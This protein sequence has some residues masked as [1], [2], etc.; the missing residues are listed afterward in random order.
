MTKQELMSDEELVAY[1]DKHVQNS[2]GFTSGQ[3][4]AERLENFRFYMGLPFGNEIEGR[5][6]VVMTDVF[7]TIESMLPSFMRVFTST[8][9][10][11]IFEPN[12]QEDEASAEQATE[13][14][15]YLIMEKNPGFMNTY[16]A[17]KDALLSKNCVA[18]V[19]YDENSEEITEDYDELSE[20]EAMAILND[21]DVEELSH[22]VQLRDIGNDQTLPIYSMKIKKTIPRAGLKWEIIPPEEFLISRRSPTIDKAEFVAHRYTKPR[23]E[24]IKEGYDPDMVAKLPANDDWF[25][26]QEKV[27]RF[28]IEDSSGLPREEMSTETDQV[29]I[30]ES[31]VHVD[32]DGDGYAERRRIVTCGRELLKNEEAENVFFVSGTCI[33]I[34]HKFFGIA[35]ADT[36]K[37]F[38]LVN[39]QLIRLSLDNMYSMLAGRFGAVDGQVNFD[40]ML[41]VRP[42]GI[43]RVKNPNALF[44]LPTPNIGQPVFDMLEYMKQEREQRAGVSRMTQGLQPDAINKTATGVAKI[45]G[46]S[47]QRLELMAKILAETFFCELFRAAFKLVIKFEPRQN[48]VRM[49]NKYV[50]VDPRTWNAQM[51]VKVNVGLGTNDK[52]MQAAGASQIIQLQ[53]EA[54]T[55]QGGV[56]GPIVSID[57]IYNGLKKFTEAVGFKN[58]DQFFSDPSTEKGQAIMQQKAQQAE[59]A[60]QKPDPLT[61]DIQLKDARERERTAVEAANAMREHEY[62]MLQLRQTHEVKMEELALEKG[63]LLLKQ[64]QLEHEKF[65]TGLQFAE[66]ES[67]HAKETVHDQNPQAGQPAQAQAK[68]PKKPK[69]EAKDVR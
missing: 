2:L 40:D 6:Q 63:N 17:C 62:K 11:C 60:A 69:P 57:N 25:Y 5:S 20:Q 8:D 46:A 59:E 18:K 44:P 64:E 41:T 28:A 15:N 68:R 26:N 9:K 53:K 48:I 24:L 1:V 56:D 38:Q 49:R 37:T 30:I 39:S 65:K 34:P 23:G 22:S 3:L 27:E 35:A 43:V 47:E 29:S 14:L 36:L 10:L 13:Y 32:Y 66:K 67:N 21:G 51:D 31:Y 7:D 4:Q 16:T 45:M 33:P 52:S 58:T 61:M 12:G 50:P 54:I 19:W 42:G 55:Y